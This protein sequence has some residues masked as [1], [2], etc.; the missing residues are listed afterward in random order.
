MKK[1]SQNKWSFDPEKEIEDYC[2]S[3]MHRHEQV[4]KQNKKTKTW[5]WDYP[6]TAAICHNYTCTQKDSSFSHY[7]DAKCIWNNILY[8]A[9]RKI[10]KIGTALIGNC[11]E[12]HA[13][14]RY[15][16]RFAENNLNNLYFS[17]ARRPRTK[18]II[19]Y[20][21]NCKQTFPQL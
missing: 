13:A 15:M 6:A 17:T 5:Y 9:L 12:Q 8:N 7:P 10:N 16:K 18:E 21:S 11:A 1:K 4:L 19:P 14:N 3:I 20:C 2:F